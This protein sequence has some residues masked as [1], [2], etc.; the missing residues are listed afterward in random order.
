MQ[1]RDKKIIIPSAILLALILI[2]GLLWY[3]QKQ[4]LI[5]I[6]PTR[7]DREFKRILSI[8]RSKFKPAQGVTTEQ[9]EAEIKN[10]EER[11][12][13]VEA[14]PNN[15]QTWF[16][17]GYTKEFLNDHEGAA[18]AWERAFELQPLSFLIAVNLANDYQYFL[19]NYERAEFYY[20][21]A[22]EVRP[23]YTQ[24]YQ[25]LS[26]LY[27]FNWKEKQDKFEPL[28]VEA[29]K[30]DPQNANAYTTT[31]V[32]FFAQTGN[33]SRAKEYLALLKEVDPAGA[34]ELIQTYPVL[35]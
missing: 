26:D 20:R 12:R 32:E 15:A 10:L 34:Q 29:I 9:L 18:L 14:D 21:K 31:L 3:Y 19:K 24:A 23:D 33:V 27:R 1:F 5:K 35:K 25:G 6:F 16:D 4:G 28:M 13:K 11:K 2:G 7:E 22:I 30:N 17:F 8:D